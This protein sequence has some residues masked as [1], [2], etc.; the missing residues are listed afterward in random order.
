MNNVNIEKITKALGLNRKMLGVEWHKDKES[1]ILS[2]SL[3]EE[4]IPICKIVDLASQGKEIKIK[5]NSIK[6][7]NELDVFGINQIDK[8]KF[9]SSI[10]ESYSVSKN[11][12]AHKKY[13]NELNYGIEMYP[14]SEEKNPD[15]VII[16]CTAKDVMRIMQ[17]YVRYYG[18]A[19]NLCTLGTQGI[20]SDLIVTPIINNDINI[21]LLSRN[22]RADGKFAKEEM[23]VSIPVNMFENIMKGVLETVNLTENNQPKREILE[24]LSYPEELG[25]GIKMNY[26]Y[27]IQGMEY[28]KYCDNCLSNI[29]K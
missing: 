16:I 26:D 8:E 23:G 14:L 24:R 13:F 12:L 9:N 11:V 21:S 19:K 3:N 28:S 29:E 18:V 20:C 1:Y 5:L 7:S 17:G 25:F 2:K 4:N 6:C 27:A 22:S 10:Y 15:L